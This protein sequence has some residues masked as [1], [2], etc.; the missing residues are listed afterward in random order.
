MWRLENM[1]VDASTH[2]ELR[3]RTLEM[4]CALRSP[5]QGAPLPLAVT[6]LVTNR[7]KAAS[8]ATVMTTLRAMPQ[9]VCHICQWP[10]S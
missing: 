8:A 3:L 10:I 5:P 6:H 1:R 2:E 9:T 4:I 7:E